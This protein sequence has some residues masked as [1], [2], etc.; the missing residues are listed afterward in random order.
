MLMKKRA[1][2]RRRSAGIGVALF[3]TAGLLGGAASA[4]GTP[5]TIASFSVTPVTEGEKGAEG[6]WVELSW[7]TEGADRVRLLRDRQE[8]RG[9]HQLPNGEIGWPLSMGGGLKMRLKAPAVFELVASNDGGQVSKIVEVETTGKPPAPAP[10]GPRILSFEAKPRTIQPGGTVRFSWQTENAGLVRLYDD[11]GELESRIELPSGKLG[12][13][14]RM[15]GAV[16]ESPGRS[17]TYRLV[18]LSKTGKTSKSLEVTV[19][20]DEAAAEDGECT[21]T[22]SITGKYGK[23]TDAVGVFQA[24]AGG[25]GDFL[26]KSSV[27][28]TRD[29]RTK[30]G[31][32]TSQRSSLKVPPGEYFLVP[33][34]GGEDGA[35]PFAV[36]YKPGRAAFTCRGGNSGRISF[37]ADFAEY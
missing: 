36:I 37:K 25:L 10:R 4:A 2:N 14:L 9:R 27:R 15:N 24:R 20:G 17:T 28:T 6:N 33:S 23:F 13:P 19:A 18:A 5:P 22:A 11:Q 1:A 31:T 26:F 34:G 21:V 29:H 3:V 12:W 16:Q 30:G 32:T 35:G 8:M 7:Q